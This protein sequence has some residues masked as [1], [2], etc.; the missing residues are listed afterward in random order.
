M[1]PEV[2]NKLASFLSSPR[3]QRCIVFAPGGH[4]WYFDMLCGLAKDD[5]RDVILLQSTAVYRIG[6][7]TSTRHSIKPGLTIP[8]RTG[9]QPTIKHHLRLH[10][11]LFLRAGVRENET[12]G[13]YARTGNLGEWK[14]A[15]YSQQR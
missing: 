10:G 5:Y 4:S 15:I 1:V 12:G 6:C 7:T 3:I 13:A 14:G 11:G 9:Q 8:N 2:L